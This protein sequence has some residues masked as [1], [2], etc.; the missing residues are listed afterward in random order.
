M[1][2][3]GELAEAAIKTQVLCKKHNAPGDGTVLNFERFPSSPRQTLRPGLRPKLSYGSRDRDIM[4]SSGE[5][6]V[7]NDCT[8]WYRIEISAA[9][10]VP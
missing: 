1:P 6:D 2:K 7:E 9:V 4:L 10:V 3:S 5:N 8:I